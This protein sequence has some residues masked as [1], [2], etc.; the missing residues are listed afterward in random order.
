[1]ARRILITPMRVGLIPT[2]V[3]SRSEPGAMLAATRKKAA[4]EISAGTSISVAV[5][6]LPPVTAITPSSTLTGQPKPPSMRSVWSRVGAGSVTE[7]QPSA[8]RPA[9]ST[10]DFTWA[11]AMGRS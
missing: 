7:V 2:W 9:S 10:Q 1:M 5:S 6:A 11:L 8:Y 3:S 4:E